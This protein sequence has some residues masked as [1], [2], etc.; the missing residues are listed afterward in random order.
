M[1]TLIGKHSGRRLVVPSQ[2]ELLAAVESADDMGFC[3]FCG[4]EAY[5]IEPDSHALECE[6]CNKLGLYGAEQLL[7]LGL[8]HA[9]DAE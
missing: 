1:K 6:E 9:D 7:L 4:E 8:Y 3:I 2:S 5:M